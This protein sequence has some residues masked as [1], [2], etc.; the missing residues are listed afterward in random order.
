M[1]TRPPRGK[2][3]SKDGLIRVSEV[4]KRH[5]FAELDRCV[6]VVGYSMPTNVPAMVEAQHVLIDT[7]SWRTISQA[8]SLG[9]AQMLQKET[10]KQKRLMTRAAQA[11]RWEGRP[12]VKEQSLKWLI[13]NGMITA[14]PEDS[15][16]AE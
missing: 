15:E 4:L 12:A 9:L 5:A 11:K 10:E 6:D 8:L 7:Y 14:A 1:Q 16:A 2:R 3:L 13:S